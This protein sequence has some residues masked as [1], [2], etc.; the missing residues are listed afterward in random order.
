MSPGTAKQ[1][2]GCETA[3]MTRPPGA[4]VPIPPG[5]PAP[6]AFS[7]LLS[8]F[9][10]LLFGCSSPLPH[11]AAVDPSRAIYRGGQPSPQGWLDLQVLGVSNVI[12]LNA[13]SEAED[14]VPNEMHV[15]YDPIS[16]DQQLF[17]VP[18]AEIDAAIG[19]IQPGTYVH[20]QHGQDRTGLVVACYR[21]THDRWPRSAARAEMLTLGF[22]PAL[23][24]LNDLWEH[25][26]SSF[27]SLP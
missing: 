24:G 12:K 23:R 15:F 4:H 8:A 14:I 16:L 10:I 18:S 6:R 1:K 22:H 7:F 20:C 21:L 17:G 3:A 11:F 26:S 13:S 9:G 5:K 2:A 25:Y 19:W 27:P